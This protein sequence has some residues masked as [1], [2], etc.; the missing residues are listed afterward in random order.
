MTQYHS[1]A[2]ADHLHQVFFGGNWTV[3]CFKNQLADVSITSAKER[4]GK[5]NTILELTYHIAY[6][7]R[8]QLRAF[9]TGI[10]KGKDSE[11]FDHPNI[12]TEQEWQQM[13]QDI[14]EDSEALCAHVRALRDDQLSEDF[15]GGG[16]GSYSRN[17]MGLIEHTH[18]HLGQTAM[19][20]R[21]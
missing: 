18:Y 17:I 6:F 13:I 12:V 11:S 21:M 5:L 10:I 20:K 4:K 19:L 9:E 7:V 1:Q 2:L 3:S 8:V 16:Y 14:L 15:I